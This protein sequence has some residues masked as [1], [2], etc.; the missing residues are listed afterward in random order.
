MYLPNST[1]NSRM[2]SSA[3]PMLHHATSM[4]TGWIG[5]THFGPYHKIHY[6]DKF[7]IFADVYQEVQQALQFLIVW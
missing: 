5:L 4:G 6:A 1:K 7:K 3:C 2:A